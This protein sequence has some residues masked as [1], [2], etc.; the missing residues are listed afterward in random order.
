MSLRYLAFDGIPLYNCL[1]IGDTVQIV[2]VASTQDES[3]KDWAFVTKLSGDVAQLDNY[4]DIAAYC[5]SKIQS[6]VASHEAAADEVVQDE[7][8]RNAARSFRT[9]F[10]LPENERLVCFYSC[11]YQQYQNQGW[12][13]VGENYIGFYAYVM[14]AE[15][16]VMLGRSWTN[17]VD[18]TLMILF[19]RTLLL[20]R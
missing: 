4:D 20:I 6:I 17:F 11:A 7:K 16:K 8:H 14:G 15:T 10:D 3:E 19:L 1:G 9:I 18:R 12:L 2:S 13:Y 5:L